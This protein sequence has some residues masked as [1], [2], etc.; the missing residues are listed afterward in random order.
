MNHKINYTVINEIKKGQTG[1]GLLIENDGCVSGNEDMVN[2]IN[3]DISNHKQFVIPDHFIVNAVFQKYGIKNANGR[4]YPENILRPEVEKYI[5]EKIKSP[6]GN[7]AIGA[8]DHPAASTLSLHDVTHKIL[9]LHW[10]NRTL[11]GQL[12]LHL[13]PGYRKY[14]VASTTGDLAANLI[15]DNIL[16]G[17]SSRGLGDVEDR[18]GVLT[19]TDYQLIGWD[20]VGE[21]STPNAYIKLNS[22]SLRPFIENKEDDENKN[23]LN[24]K[25]NKINKILM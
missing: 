14:G 7:S 12:E 16:I 25:I 10:D 15:L 24:E 5:N 4:I 19:V 9:E 11:V 18:L 17:V 8:L 1:H 13:S 2:Q 21:P 23:E 22:D 6:A 20:I 3:E